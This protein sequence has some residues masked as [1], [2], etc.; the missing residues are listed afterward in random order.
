MTPGRAHRLEAAIGSVLLGKPRPIRLVLTGLLAG[1]HL[2]IEDV[3]GVGKTLLARALARCLDASFTR[4]QFTPD[5]L[6]SD[7]LGTSIFNQKS[8]QFEF[9]PGPI[10][11]HVI[12][13]DEINR[14][15]PR[16]QSA[17]LEAMNA[18]SVSIDGTTYPLPEPFLVLATQNPFE[19]E[20]TYPLPESQLDR[21]MMRIGIGYPARDAEREMLLTQQKSNPVDA[22]EP[23]LS[24]DD[25]RDAQRAVR[26]IRVDDSLRDYV[27]AIVA[28]T[29]DSSQLRLGVSPRG[30]NALQ[31]ASQAYA[32][33]DGRDY[34]IPDDIKRLSLPVLAH[35]LVLDGSYP[36][37]ASAADRERALQDIL[38]RVEVPL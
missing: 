23:I 37:E 36:G 33:L 18:A 27:L 24:V 6:P 28:A 35:R 14:T 11:A 31:R 13:A 9:K 21:F 3:P 38:E 7:L 25:I 20:G 12:L 8:N 30:A 32:F 22:L 1:G 10:F 34:I 17:L 5:L 4:L 2:L 26:E 29:R 19:F 15:T 16:T